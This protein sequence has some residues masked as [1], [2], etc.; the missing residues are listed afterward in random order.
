MAFRSADN[1]IRRLVRRAR[2]RLPV[3]ERETARL[4]G[5]L[6]AFQGALAQER[7]GIRAELTAMNARIEQNASRLDDVARALDLID[8][9]MV[10]TRAAQSAAAE[11]VSVAQAA[12]DR[13]A[14]SAAEAM[15][16]A[17]AAAEATSAS[18]A[19]AT[20]TG[21]ALEGVAERLAMLDSAF[22]R[23]TELVRDARQRVARLESRDSAPSDSEDSRGRRYRG[24]ETTK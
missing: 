18:Q 2:R 12:A 11:A 15:S 4:G 17:Q 3:S 20:S 1:R 21:D 6:S 23:I 14:S 19:A 13:A 7:V 5:E 22:D 8:A 16:G 24:V 9:T 10:D